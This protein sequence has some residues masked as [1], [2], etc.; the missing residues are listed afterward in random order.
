MCFFFGVYVIGFYYFNKD[1][2]FSAWKSLMQFLI[3]TKQFFR[4]I[5]IMLTTGQ[6]YEKVI[7]YLIF[8]ILSGYGN[9]MSYWLRTLAF[10]TTQVPFI[11]CLQT[12]QGTRNQREY[13]LLVVS[14]KF[15]SKIKLYINFD[16]IKW[17][18]KRKGISCILCPSRKRN[19]CLCSLWPVKRVDMFFCLGNVLVLRNASTR[20][21][22]HMWYRMVHGISEKRKRQK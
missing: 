17:I 18:R 11:S 8:V 1:F 7:D 19:S 9:L 13:H 3:S 16:S 4:N 6:A 10:C 2:W 20:T 12:T 14:N 5:L 21:G 22:K 15:I